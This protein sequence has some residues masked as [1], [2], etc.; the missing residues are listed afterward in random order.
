MNAWID[1]MIDPRN[2][3]YTTYTQQDLVWLGIL[4]NI[5][6]VESML[7][8]NEK[9]NEELRKAISVETGVFGA[10]MEVSFTNVG[11]TTILL[12]K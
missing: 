12:E 10:D 4:K 7:Q 11:P 5:C 6:G 1:E 9:F 3:S 2:C 8:M